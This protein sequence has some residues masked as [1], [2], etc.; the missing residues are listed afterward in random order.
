MPSP[1][2]IQIHTLVSY[3]GTLLN[4]DDAGLAKRIRIG[5]ATRTRVSSQCL[6]RHWRTVD[7]PRSIRSLGRTL[8]V[9][10]ERTKSAVEK[11]IA[12]PLRGEFDDEIVDAIEAGTL[13]ALYGPRAKDI[14][15]RQALLLGS[16]EIEYLASQARTVAGKAK[17]AAQ[18]KKLLGELFAGQKANIRA[19]GD[20]NA[21]SAGLES[22]LFGRMVTADTRANIDGALSVGHAFTVHAENSGV[23]FVAAVDDLIGP[24]DEAGGTAM[25]VDQELTSGLYYVY[26]VVDVPSLVANTSGH[27]R[28]SW[29]EIDEHERDIAAKVVEN[30]LH[31][32]A[33]V[34]PGAKRGSTAPFA[35]ADLVLVELGERQ[36]R[37]LANAFAEPVPLRGEGS[38]N[39]RALGALSRELAGLD[40]MYGP[41]EVRW[42]ASRPG[43]GVEGVRA[44]PLPE[45]AQRTADVVVRAAL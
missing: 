16:P 17:D 1:R 41:E 18:A 45:L 26:V 8:G 43:L 9:T 10:A 23:D 6:K 39:E 37:S 2:F 27:P 11:L 20:A 29:Q 31:L 38:L 12:G 15:T 13:V 4:R 24:D 42:Q 34:S 14:K 30:L 7:D 44:M 35:A 33:T 22:A 40:A 32:I 19:L 36:P 25:L 21:L 5:S 3:H 28:D